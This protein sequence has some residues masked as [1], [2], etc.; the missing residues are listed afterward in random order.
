[1]KHPYWS[2][3][4]DFMLTLKNETTKCSQVNVLLAKEN[5]EAKKSVRAEKRSNLRSW[6]GQHKKNPRKTDARTKYQFWKDWITYW[7]AIY[8]WPTIIDVV[9]ILLSAWNGVLAQ[10]DWNYSEVKNDCVI[11]SLPFVH[12]DATMIQMSAL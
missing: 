12:T 7:A 1:M 10:S 3:R 8:W 9:I 2:Y 5:W 6:Q 11:N 4:M